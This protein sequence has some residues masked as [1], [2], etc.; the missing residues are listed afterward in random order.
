MMEERERWG[1]LM[2]ESL[3]TDQRLCVLMKDML[4]DCQ[5]IHHYVQKMMK[6]W[7]SCGSSDSV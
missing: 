2:L 5:H 6:D 7:K 1:E 3:W 4:P